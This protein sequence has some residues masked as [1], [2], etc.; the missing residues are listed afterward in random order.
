MEH[1][2]Q[3]WIKHVYFVEQESEDE[4]EDEKG[5]EKGKV[6][7]GQDP[8]AEKEDGFHWSSRADSSEASFFRHFSTR[9]F[10]ARYHRL[11]QQLLLD[12]LDTMEIVLLL[13]EK[14][15]DVF[16][17]VFQDADATTKEVRF[18]LIQLESQRD[19]FEGR[20]YLFR[21]CSETYRCS[22][23]DLEE[24]QKELVRIAKGNQ[25]CP[26]TVEEYWELKEW[27]RQTSLPI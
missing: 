12:L 22:V 18:N 25:I 14:E 20:R 2:L 23:E 4:E 3:R 19:M 10:I 11:F 8:E 27:V 17:E 9:Q 6:T 21:F 13:R 16:S 1:S 5:E 24:H 7:G 26:E 15:S